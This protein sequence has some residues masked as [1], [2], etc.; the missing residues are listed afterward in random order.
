MKK[1]ILFSMALCIVFSLSAC[2]KNDDGKKTTTKATT[3]TTTTVSTTL[4]TT[5][6]NSEYEPV[7]ENAFEGVTVDNVFETTDVTYEFDK[8][9]NQAYNGLYNVQGKNEIVT[10]RYS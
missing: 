9:K 3:K 1:I 8:R 10:I 2:S 7:I 4:S 6:T 5:T